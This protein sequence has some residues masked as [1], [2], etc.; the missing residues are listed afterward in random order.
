M[1]NT[2][3]SPVREARSSRIPVADGEV[4][5]LRGGDGPPLLFLHAA[6]GAGRWQPIHERLATRFDVIA[7]DH[8]GF[9]H[10]D[11]LERLDDIGDL[12]MHYRE[13]CAVLDVD[14]LP[15]VGASFGGWIA[16]ELA[17]HAPQL[18]DRLVLIAPA[19]LR[20]PEAPVTDLFILRP[21]EV[22]PVLFADPTCAAAAELLPAEPDVDAILAAYR[23]LGSLA[24]F[25]WKPF[26]SDP[27]LEGRLRFVSAP[28]LVVSPE[29]DRLIPRT[30]AERYVKRIPDARHVV[31]D[32]AGHAVHLERP[33]ETARA[34]LDFLTTS[35]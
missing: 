20:I 8:P 15:V 14:H 28:T 22:P 16:A 4:H 7:P 12:V 9:G 35:G 29:T 21:E 24:R 26:M 6:G 30:H 19:G 1:A 18:V 17:V 33:A 27:K 32:G 5:L 10:S 3:T 13:L 2:A 25:A 11:D 34:V 31:V 23:E